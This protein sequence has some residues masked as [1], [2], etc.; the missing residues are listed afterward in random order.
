[1]LLRYQN[2]ITIWLTHK[3]SPL[4]LTI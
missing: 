4:Y 1:M 2:F 3:I